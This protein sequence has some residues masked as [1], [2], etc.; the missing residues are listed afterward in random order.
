MPLHDLYCETRYVVGGMLGQEASNI[1]LELFVREMSVQK[2]HPEHR[3]NG[4]RHETISLPWYWLDLFF[5]LCRPHTTLQDGFQSGAPNV[6]TVA[7]IG[8]EL[9][10]VLGKYLVWFLDDIITIAWHPNVIS[11][12]VLWSRR[13]FPQ[14]ET[15]NKHVLTT[16]AVAHR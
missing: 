6:T 3:S 4:P 13:L 8:R 5:C 11:I 7:R 14:R 12:S 10:D 15:A 2:T 1:F 16:L 9:D